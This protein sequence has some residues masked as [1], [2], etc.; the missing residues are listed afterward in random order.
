MLI[1]YSDLIGI[2]FK[3]GGRSK[4]EGYDCYGLVCEIY[5]RAGITLPPYYADAFDSAAVNK[6]IEEAK[7]HS[8]WQQ[9]PSPRDLCI[10]AIRF[11]SPVVNHTGVYI[12]N[13]Q[14]LHT[15]ERIGVSVTRIDSPA[16]RRLIDGYYIYRG[17]QII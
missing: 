2:P 7:T 1:D 12:G 13:G 10:L 4:A 5:K 15:R 11:N 8:Y 16:W 9:I 14:F 17:G 6:Q 3:S